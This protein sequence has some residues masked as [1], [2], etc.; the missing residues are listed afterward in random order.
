MKKPECNTTIKNPQPQVGGWQGAY[1]KAKRAARKKA[2]CPN[3]G[4]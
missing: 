3:C 1:E 2:I 4:K